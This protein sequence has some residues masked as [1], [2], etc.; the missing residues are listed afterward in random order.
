MSSDKLSRKE[1]RNP[2]PFVRVTSEYWAKLIQNQ[3]TVGIGLLAV[4]VVFLVIAG[5]VRMSQSATR[6]AGAALARAMQ[7]A[8]RPVEGSMEA[9]QD[10]SATEKFKTAKEKHEAV[11]KA[12]DEVRK[13][14]AGKEAGN[15]ATVFW[16]DAMFQQGKFDDAIAG[17]QQYL[18][19]ARADDA[20]RIVANEGLGYAFEGKKD[21]DKARDAFEKMSKEALG[22]PAKARAAYHLA[23]ILEAQGKKAEAAAAFQKL[24]DEFKEAT[25]AREADERLSL[26]AMQGVPMPA[27]AKEAPKA[28][29][30]PKK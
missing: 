18:T 1:I 22:E 17:Y 28:P 7:L 19:A 4:F 23:R 30:A 21:L 24:K 5:G 2:D 25:A 12:M 13:A 14:H 27:K 26:L 10:P 8:H 3:K 11:A 15:T 6:E 20:L 16:A 29:E 9:L